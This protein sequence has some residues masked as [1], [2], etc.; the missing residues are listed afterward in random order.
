[1]SHVS[2]QDDP[3]IGLSWLIIN[4]WDGRFSA[5]I[6]LGKILFSCDGRVESGFP[7]ALPESNGLVMVLP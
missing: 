3:G 1:M 5:S 4:M 2:P 7:L 6:K